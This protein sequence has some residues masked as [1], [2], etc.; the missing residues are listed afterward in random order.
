MRYSSLN[1]THLKLNLTKKR[2]FAITK[3]GVATFNPQSPA[4]ITNKWPWAE[5]NGLTLDTTGKTRSQQ[6]FLLHI[7][8]KGKVETM[9]F[10]TEHRDE[11][12]TEAM[13]FYKS[14]ANPIQGMDFNK[15]KLTSKSIF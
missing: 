15:T 7:R 5:L 11:L 12:L 4:E 10:S 8:K 13:Q 9:K 3:D 2:L 14:V 6:E 1:R